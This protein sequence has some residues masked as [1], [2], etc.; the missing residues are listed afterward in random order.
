MNKPVF[1]IPVDIM[2]RLLWPGLSYAQKTPQYLAAVC[3]DLFP[4][5]SRLVRL[6]VVGAGSSMMF[7][8]V[9]FRK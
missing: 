1:E 9:N 5:E 7:F 4:L 8:F 3:E 2:A 6:M